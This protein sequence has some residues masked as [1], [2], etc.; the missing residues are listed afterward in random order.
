MENSN[1]FTNKYQVSKT[2]RFRLEPTGGT[3]DLLRQAQIIEGDERRNKEAITMKQILDN[4]HKQ[5][6]ER[7]CPT[8]ILKSILLKSFSK[9]IPETMM[10]AKR[11]LKISNQK[12]AKK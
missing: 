3:D 4:C 6:I 11:T 12:C 9:C 1:L 10:T 5:I 8:L 7:Y 2:L